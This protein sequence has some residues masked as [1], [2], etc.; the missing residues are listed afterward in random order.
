[1]SR[2][3]SRT[4]AEKLM[5]DGFF[6]EVIDRVPI[7]QVQEIVQHVIDQKIGYTV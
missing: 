3:I 7:P 4:E 2:G 6:A 5:I 1:M